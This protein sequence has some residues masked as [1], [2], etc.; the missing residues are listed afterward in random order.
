M[1]FILMADC[2]VIPL[3]KLGRDYSFYVRVLVRTEGKRLPLVNKDLVPSYCFWI[4][5]KW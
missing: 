1:S 3:T 4:R 2:W 5:Y